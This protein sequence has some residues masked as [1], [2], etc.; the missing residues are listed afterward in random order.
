[1]G[2]V[3]GCEGEPSGFQ[4]PIQGEGEVGRGWGGGTRSGTEGRERAGGR[5]SMRIVHTCRGGRQGRGRG[6]LHGKGATDIG[7]LFRGVV[8]CKGGT[9]TK[10]LGTCTTLPHCTVRVVRKT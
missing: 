6:H 4:V 7:K 10:Q 3:R 9:Q 5:Q 1:M 2:E 8:G